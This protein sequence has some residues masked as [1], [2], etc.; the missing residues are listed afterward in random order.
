MTNGS[1]E[2]RTSHHLAMVLHNLSN[3]SYQCGDNDQAGTELQQ[4]LEIYR[5]LYKAEGGNPDIAGRL[6]TQYGNLAILFR[7][8]GD[9]EKCEEAAF[10]GV[11][12]GRTSL[13]PLSDRPYLLQNYADSEVR[14][15]EVYAET[16]RQELAMTT[17]L[18]AKDTLQK[19]AQPAVNEFRRSLCTCEVNL[20]NLYRAVDRVPEAQESF[21]HARTLCEELLAA[22]PDNTDFQAKL[23]ALVLN[24]AQFLLNCRQMESAHESLVKR[25]ISSPAS[26]KCR[27]IIRN[28]NLAWDAPRSC[29]GSG[30]SPAARR[31]RP[32]PRTRPPWKP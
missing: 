1:H 25:R 29:R 22:D 4:A 12:I 13:A 21:Q 27:P 5:T 19:L 24:Q 26:S 2:T 7:Q 8:Q 30:C 31:S 15:A 11:E 20:A 18:H 16:N 10:Q 9:I 6:V 23:A 28:T 32:S 14:L 17:F 3:L